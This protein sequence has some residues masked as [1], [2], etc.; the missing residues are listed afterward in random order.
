MKSPAVLCALV[1]S[2][3]SLWSAGPAWADNNYRLGGGYVTPPAGASR[4]P[5]MP[6]GN[7]GRW[8]GGGQGDWNGGPPGRGDGPGRGN[9]PALERWE[10]ND[11]PPPRPG[12]QPAWQDRPVPVPASRPT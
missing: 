11:P 7:A 6:P 9:G 5:V 2:G 3:V 8:Q 1:L 4:P 10:R 12:Y